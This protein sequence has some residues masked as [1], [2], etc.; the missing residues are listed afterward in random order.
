MFKDDYV[1]TYFGI[2]IPESDKNFMKVPKHFLANM[3]K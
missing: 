2:V 1:V 3:I